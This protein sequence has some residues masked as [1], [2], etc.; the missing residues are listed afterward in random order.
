MNDSRF[1]SL[2]D[3]E[4]YRAILMWRDGLDTRSIADA[5]HRHESVVANLLG[6][7]REALAYISAEAAE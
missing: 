4:F 7:I 2:D 3:D 1:S 5:L 6:S